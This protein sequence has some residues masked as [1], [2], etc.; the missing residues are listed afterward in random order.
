MSAIIGNSIG[1]GNIS[2]VY[3]ALSTIGVVVLVVDL[4]IIMTLYLIKDWLVTVYTDQEDV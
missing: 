1:K 3:R 4:I 2:L